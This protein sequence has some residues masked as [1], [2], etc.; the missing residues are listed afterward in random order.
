MTHLLDYKSL[1]MRK[2]VFEVCD[3]GRLKPA[4]SATEAR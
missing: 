1:I 2:S 4:W 3:Q